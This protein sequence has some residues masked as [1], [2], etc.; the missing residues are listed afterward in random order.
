MQHHDLNPFEARIDK[1]IILLRV[2]LPYKILNKDNYLETKL[3]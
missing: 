1:S 3:S 2:T